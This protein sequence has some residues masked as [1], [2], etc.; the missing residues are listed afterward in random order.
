MFVLLGIRRPLSLAPVDHS[1]RGGTNLVRNAIKFAASHGGEASFMSALLPHRGVLQL[2]QNV[3][4]RVVNRVPGRHFMHV[5]QHSVTQRN[6]TQPKNIYAL[7]NKEFT[8][9][10]TGTL[11]LADHLSPASDAAPR[12]GRLRSANRNCLIV[13]RCRLS[14]YGCRTFHYAGPTVWNSLP[15][16]L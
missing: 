13:P 8:T 1:F 9:S 10:R 14:T 4:S 16:E 6:V 12:C 7:R 3:V 2:L 15:D 5:F 11:Y